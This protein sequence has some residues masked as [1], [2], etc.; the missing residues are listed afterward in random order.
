MDINRFY[1][2][3]DKTKL[4]KEVVK[5][6]SR[7]I[8]NYS[9]PGDV[10]TRISIIDAPLIYPDG[11][12][13]NWVYFKVD[14]FSSEFK[15]IS[16][17]TEEDLNSII[18][19]LLSRE[20]IDEERYHELAKK[21]FNKFIEALRS[22]ENVNTTIEET[23]EINE[24]SK[25]GNLLKSTPAKILLKIGDYV[26]IEINKDYETTHGKFIKYTYEKDY[27]DERNLISYPKTDSY[28]GANDVNSLIDKMV[29]TFLNGRNTN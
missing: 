21:Y 19:D 5:N 24:Y 15:K 14:G 20:V 23:E 4:K 22:Y 6:D 13:D 28:L 25:K 27:E 16:S 1:S 12:I 9:L 17:L 11:L 8:A 18:E 7:E 26:I 29:N 2:I 10:V 3:L